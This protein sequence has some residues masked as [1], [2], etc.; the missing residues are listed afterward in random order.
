[1]AATDPSSSTF[2]G[3][4]ATDG[5]DYMYTEAVSGSVRTLTHNG[6]PNHHETRGLWPS[7]G[8]GG[9]RNADSVVGAP[10]T[11]TPPATTWEL[12]APEAATTVEPP[13]PIIPG[14]SPVPR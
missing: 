4:C 2:V 11:S 8:L 9:S 1:M 7:L 3:A 13:R 10:P 6:R 12:P 14:P 5:S